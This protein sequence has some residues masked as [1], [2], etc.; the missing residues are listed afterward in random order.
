MGM[1]SGPCAAGVVWVMAVAVVEHPTGMQAVNV[2]VPGSY[3][4]LDQLVPSPTAT[5]S[6][7]VCIVLTVLRRAW[8]L[9]SFPW[10]GGSCSHVTSNSDQ[11]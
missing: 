6:S 5:H 8:S 2:G 7:A 3:D 9:L 10:L 11:G 4:G 1:F